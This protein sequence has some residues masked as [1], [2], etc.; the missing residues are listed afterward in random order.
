MRSV[1]KKNADKEQF[2][3]SISVSLSLHTQR[4]PLTLFFGALLPVLGPVT[5]HAEKLSGV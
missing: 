3:L 5:A 2:D 4:A 1:C